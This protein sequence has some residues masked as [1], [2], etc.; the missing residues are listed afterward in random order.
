MSINIAE[1]TVSIRELE[2]KVRDIV[3]ERN[4]LQESLKQ[5]VQK[6]KGLEQRI[7]YLT[8]DYDKQIEHQKG[9]V[10]DMRKLNS[11]VIAERDNLSERQEA[12]KVA[13]EKMAIRVLGQEV[14]ANAP[15]NVNPL[16]LI[17]A[18]VKYLQYEFDGAK[19]IVEQENRAA[20][21]WRKRAETAEQELVEARAAQI[22]AA[23][24]EEV[25]Q[26]QQGAPNHEVLELVTAED[27]TAWI[28]KI[29]KLRALLKRARPH[30][31]ELGVGG[32]GWDI[33]H[34]AVI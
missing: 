24:V 28:N 26:F 10:V 22:S 18:R 3:S 5:S 32:I 4:T 12:T 19:R 34:E 21:E 11:W 8:R 15:C 29:A 16:E 6:V 27:C 25:P 13:I 33:D 31:K 9:V 7:E 30:C 20:E 2:V 14:Y 17:E 1:L 23:Y